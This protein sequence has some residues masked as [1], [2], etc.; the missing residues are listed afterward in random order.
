M[1]D[2][3]EDIRG[4]GSRASVMDCERECDKKAGCN[5][6]VNCASKGA[7]C[8]LKNKILSGAE[9]TKFHSSCTTHYRDCGK[10]AK[11]KSQSTVAN[12]QLKMV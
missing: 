11:T 1:R 8:I 9:D 3:G 6:F 5:S 12:M 10:H 2:E 4:G 7:Y